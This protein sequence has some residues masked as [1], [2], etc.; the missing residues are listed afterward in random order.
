MIMQH[1]K[2]TITEEELAVITDTE[3]LITKATV[4]QKMKLLLQHLQDRISGTI[5]KYDLPSELSR[6]H[7]KISSG[8][9]Y[10]GL[11]YLILDYPRVF[12]KENIFA[13]RSMFW[14]G[15][16]FLFTL[17]LQGKFL[18]QHRTVLADNLQNQQTGKLYISTGNDPWRHHLEEDNF[19]LF[20]SDFTLPSELNFLK[21]ARKLELS[22]WKKMP[23]FGAGTFE[24]FMKLSGTDNMA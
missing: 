9:N 16:Y 14:W 4:L 8:E 6:I 3:F 24:L 1:T 11:P 17:H 5:K 19:V 2:I 22:E 10:R 23:D 13:F 7:G 21:I 18:E 20:S 12:D 15:N